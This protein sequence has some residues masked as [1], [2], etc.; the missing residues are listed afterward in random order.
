MKNEVLDAILAEYDDPKYQPNKDGTTHCNQFIHAVLVR[1]G[2]LGFGSLIPLAD[3]MLTLMNGSPAFHRILDQQEAIRLANTGA[4]IIAG[5]TSKQLGESHGHVVFLR[6]GAAEYSTTWKD[7]APRGVSIG[8]AQATFVGKKLSWAF[9]KKP[10]YY[11]L[12]STL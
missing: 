3:D 4:C 9:K 1:L 5:L 11:A 6:P 8:S 2:Y 10:E 12:V 7:D